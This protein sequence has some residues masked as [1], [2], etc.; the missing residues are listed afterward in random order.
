MFLGNCESD[1]YSFCQ[2]CCKVILLKTVFCC[3]FWRLKILVLWQK[4]VEN[5]LMLVHL[6]SPKKQ[7]NWFYKNLHNLGMV[8]CRKLPDPS[9]NCICNA[10]SIGVCS[11]FNEL[12]LA[13]SAYWLATHLNIPQLRQIAEEKFF[14]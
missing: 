2:I 4:I 13:W 10:L 5:L 3:T 1:T 8:G 6:F 7:H 9:L 11:H 12:I 14:T